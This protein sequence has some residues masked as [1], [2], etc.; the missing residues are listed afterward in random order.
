MSEMSLVRTVWDPEKLRAASRLLHDAAN[1]LNTAH[2]YSR[3][4][5]DPDT[6]PAVKAMIESA[7]LCVCNAMPDS[8]FDDVVTEETV[9]TE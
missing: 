6:L 4:E 1:H 5:P 3:T 9:S 2:P 7:M 8:E